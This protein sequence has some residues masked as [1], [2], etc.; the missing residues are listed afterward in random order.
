VQDVRVLVLDRDMVLAYVSENDLDLS[1][2]PKVYKVLHKRYILIINNY[3]ECILDFSLA[4]DMYIKRFRT[5]ENIKY[6]IHKLGEAHI[7]CAHDHN[8]SRAQGL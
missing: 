2:V 4:E 5:H 1:L 6:L 7:N 8:I 3:Y